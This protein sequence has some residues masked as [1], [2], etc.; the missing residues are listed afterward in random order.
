MDDH[1]QF[2]NVKTSQQKSEEQNEEDKRLGSRNPITTVFALS[3]G[4]LISQLCQSFYGVIDSFWVAKALESSDI[5][6]FGAVFVVEF[7]SLS[8]SQYLF[9][10]LTARIAYL[11]SIH[12]QSEINQL[13]VDFLRVGLI[14]G[15]IVPCIVLP[16][17]KPLV[18]WFGASQELA[19]NCLLYMWPTCGAC[20]FN[21]V[22]MMNSAIVQAQG[23]STLFG[24]IQLS[25]FILN[26]GVFDP[27]FLLGFKTKMWGA[28]AATIIAQAFVG[29]TLTIIIFLGK[30]TIHPTLSLFLK[31]FS[32]HTL[33][34]LEVGFSSLIA[35]ISTT[36]PTLFPKKRK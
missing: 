33:P 34:A 21:Y 16:I 35:N 1:S 12:L 25:A 8:V 18:I 23:R 14:L 19:A 11:E 20:F 32:S 15:I 24:I 26:V 2:E 36:L 27:L 6:V 13:Y 29:I 22:Y 10:S 17:T 4:P 28:S 7:I 30:L 5:A 31:K 3:V 9:T